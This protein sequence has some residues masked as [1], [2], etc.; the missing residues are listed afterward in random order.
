MTCKYFQCYYIGNHYCGCGGVF[1]KSRR[2]FN[3]AKSV[4]L[5]NTIRTFRA[6]K[7]TIATSTSSDRRCINPIVQAIPL[8]YGEIFY[9]HPYGDVFYLCNYVPKRGWDDLYDYRSRDF[10][11]GFKD[12]EESAIQYVVDYLIEH[13]AGHCTLVAVPSHN[14]LGISSACHEVIKRVVDA[15]GQ[16]RDVIDGSSCLIRTSEIEPA[17]L[18][19]DRDIDVHLD[20]IS[21]VSSLEEKLK[22]RNVLI[23]DD[24]T[25]SGNSFK[26]CIEIISSKVPDVKN[27]FCFAVGKTISNKDLKLG[28]IIDVEAKPEEYKDLLQDFDELEANYRFVTDKDKNFALEFSVKLGID[29]KYIISKEDTVLRNSPICPYGDPY[30]Y[31]LAVQQMQIYEPFVVII[32]KQVA[33]CGLAQWLGMTPLLIS[34]VEKDSIFTVTDLLAAS[35]NLGNAL[36][37]VKD[38]YLLPIYNKYDVFPLIISNIDNYVSKELDRKLDR[39]SLLLQQIVQDKEKEKQL[40]KE[41]ALAEF[42]AKYPA[43]AGIMHKT[44]GFGEVVS[45]NVPYFTVK[46]I[47]TDGNKKI[48]KFEIDKYSFYFKES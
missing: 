5:F 7:Y 41:K 8:S 30:P 36:S 18:G 16:K 25:T 35:Y 43:G 33:H 21:L 46:F 38:N 40:A 31:L 32:T 27:I 2:D 23:L 20:S 39:V 4:Q 15:I 48:R 12:K 44:L 6:D 29:S 19:G 14:V 10:V 1:M 17:H 34:D 26:A 11:L 22:G 45:V 24:I 47:D 42:I 28:F 3:Q 9:N 37:Y 13:L